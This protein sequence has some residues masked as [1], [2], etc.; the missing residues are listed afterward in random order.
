[1]SL[2]LFV[3]VDL[4]DDARARVGD[5]VGSL[6]RSLA[7]AGMAEAFRWVA[8][9]NLHL[10][11]R[12]L[13]AVD[14]D[15]AARVVAAMREPLALDA[16]TVRLGGLGAFPPRGRPRVL[17]AAVEEGRDALRALRDAIDGRLSP[18]C[19]WEPESRPFAPHLTLA[20]TRDGARFAPQVFSRLCDETAWPSVPF[21][22]SHVTLF[23]SRTLPSGPVYSAE[24]RAALRSP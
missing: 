5:A 17:H 11:L 19:R 1:V 23:S 3:A 7:G 18:L 10:T 15:A 8:I 13:G 20:R 21:P 4:P 12:F 16:A 14:D 9:E 6:R 22:A 2:R 24:A